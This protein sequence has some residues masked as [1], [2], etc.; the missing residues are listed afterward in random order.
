MRL[1]M[2]GGGRSRRSARHP[3]LNGAEKRPQFV[4]RL[5]ASLHLS[6]LAFGVSGLSQ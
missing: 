6:F 5:G 1:L 2:D 3:R 4:P